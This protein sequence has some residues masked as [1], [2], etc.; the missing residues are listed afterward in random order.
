MDK[1]FS[2]FINKYGLMQLVHT[3]CAENSN[4]EIRRSFLLGEAVINV[5]INYKVLAYNNI[6]DDNKL[7]F[8]CVSLNNYIKDIII[9]DF[10]LTESFLKV[11]VGNGF[12]EEEYKLNS[13]ILDIFSLYVTE[14]VKIYNFKEVLDDICLLLPNQISLVDTKDSKTSLQEF[15]QAKKI[16][17]PNYITDNGK[18]ITPTSYSFTTHLDI[19]E[20]NL[21]VTGVGLSKKQSQLDAA[22]KA[23]EKLNISKKNSNNTINLSNNIFDFINNCKELKG[24]KFN[25]YLNNLFG[26]N[27]NFNILPA[28]IPLRM[29]KIGLISHKR[30]AMLGS[31]V[32]K[33]FRT[34]VLYTGGSSDA[35]ELSRLEVIGANDFFLKQIKNSNFFSISDF[36][37]YK[38]GGEYLYDAYNIDCIQALF[39]LSFINEM[40][41]NQE[42]K[43]FNLTE[44][45]KAFIW[46]RDLLDN[47][48]LELDQSNF[49]LVNKLVKRLQ[50]LGLS[51]KIKKDDNVFYFL[52]TCINNKDIKYILDLNLNISEYNRELATKKLAEFI[53]KTLNR[54]D[55]SNISSPKNNKYLNTICELSSFIV[56]NSK[57]LFDPSPGMIDFIENKNT[58]ASKLEIDHLFRLASGISDDV[59]R[60][61]YIYNILK[62]ENLI[63]RQISCLEFIGLNHCNIK[64]IPKFEISDEGNSLSENKYQDLLLLNQKQEKK[65]LE[66]AIKL[67]KVDIVKNID[68]VV[69]FQCKSQFNNIETIMD[70]TQIPELTIGEV[71]LDKNP[72]IETDIESTLNKPTALD[73]LLPDNLSLVE[74]IKYF[75]NLSK[76]ELLKIWDKR[77]EILDF[78]EDAA[79]ILSLIRVN[80]GIDKKI[81]D[82]T[83]IM[84]F[85]IITSL[86]LPSL[87]TYN[88]N[89]KEKFFKINENDT[90]IRKKTM[91]VVRPKQTNFRA[92]LIKLWKNC[93][94]TG[95]N[96]LE[97]LD[98]A[99]IYPYRGE[100]DNDLS[101]GILLRT[102]IHKL[103]DRYLLSIHPINFTIHVSKYITDPQYT[104]HE[105]K[106]VKNGRVLSKHALEYHWMYFENPDF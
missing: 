33:L 95:C 87:K 76:N 17:L 2:K 27:N 32:L 34:I 26:F 9:S 42:I 50:A 3:S 82:L 61:V 46:Y 89:N 97:I 83:E 25:N 105:G 51:L 96:I 30:F 55:G 86:D 49:Y 91:M 29:K 60:F 70:E 106:V 37:F 84:D 5:A 78:S 31:I 74:R 1:K 24:Q 67:P 23:Y 80:E 103:F 19:P 20:F 73:V 66:V 47:P 6:I 28:F 79:I 85:E 101:N 45:N 104:Q 100:K 10:P 7:H 72:I 39:A 75:N 35:D 62:N 21:K 68:N 56:R 15:L 92:E 43:L 102:D 90:R 98:A 53:F 81:R 58:Y 40:Q 64:F 59:E 11:K 99:H 14:I 12:S 16:S 44:C 48:V 36:P 13:F 69:N 65:T 63:D 93:P 52:L 22:Q 41:K 77:T 94:I 18:Q 4:L 57:K 38:K 88:S 54:L 8:L 71:K